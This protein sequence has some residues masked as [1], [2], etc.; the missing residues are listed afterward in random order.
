MG[1]TTAVDI[2]NGN[3]E[4]VRRH[5]TALIP[6][7]AVNEDYESAQSTLPQSNS[8]SRTYY[9]KSAKTK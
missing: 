4:I 3:G 8:N 6:Y 9:L 5:I 2:K 1:E 7:L